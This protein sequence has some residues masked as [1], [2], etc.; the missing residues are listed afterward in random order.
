MNRE[1]RNLAELKTCSAGSSVAVQ[2][3][4]QRLGITDGEIIEA[5][6]ALE[7]RRPGETTLSRSSRRPTQVKT[8][9]DLPVVDTPLP[10]KDEPEH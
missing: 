10:L 1:A 8:V 2:S 5:A 3:L 9:D 4:A 6:T 7:L